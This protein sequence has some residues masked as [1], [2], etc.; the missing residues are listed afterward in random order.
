ML[1]A[2]IEHSGP[3][4]PRAEDPAHAELSARIRRWRR[5]RGLSQAELAERS[6]FARST[7]SK[8]E[9]GQLSPTFEILLKLARGFDVEVSELMR[10][11]NPPSLGGRL[12]VDR[13]ELANAVE[14]AN[15]RLFP[16]AAQLKDKRFQSLI[17]DFT[18]TSLADFGEWNRHDTEDMLYVLSGKLEFHSEAYETLTLTAGQSV[19]FDG[20][21]GHACLSKGKK[22]CRCLYVF[23]SN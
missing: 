19:Y 8:I 7:L 18:C 1:N 23:A 22:P 14:Y 16:L 11:E 20:R 12:A 2:E 3:S 9:N 13:G 6:G 15:H 10:P 17:V 21:M 5:A 4:G